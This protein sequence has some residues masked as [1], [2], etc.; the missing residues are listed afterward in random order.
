MKFDFFLCFLAI[1]PTEKTFAV[2][3]RRNRIDPLTSPFFILRLCKKMKNKMVPEFLM[4]FYLGHSGT[5]SGKKKCR[6]NLY[7]LWWPPKL[8]V[9]LLLFKCIFFRRFLTFLVYFLL[10]KVFFA[11]VT[12]IFSC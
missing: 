6:I 1:P 5:L 2:T 7:I 12:H 10:I 11:R 4:F 3:I 9:F 8:G